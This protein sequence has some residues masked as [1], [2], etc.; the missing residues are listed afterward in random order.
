MSA[1]EAASG[2]IK[3]LADGTL[4][5]SFDVEPRFAQ[6]AFRL[7][8]APGTPSALAALKINDG[9]QVPEAA[10][11]GILKETTASP[12]APSSEPAKRAL[13]TIC[14]WLVFR[15]K[16]NEFQD[17]TARQG[18]DGHL[19]E[20]ESAAWCRNICGVTSRSAIDG[21]PLAE[22]KFEKYIRKPWLAHQQRSNATETAK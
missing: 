17:W 16:E 6:D 2:P 14:Q 3:T 9:A 11:P 18:P 22:A 12:V 7:F 1:I 4:R 13:G 15:C 19:G 5:I 20:M 10:R 21:N 8:G